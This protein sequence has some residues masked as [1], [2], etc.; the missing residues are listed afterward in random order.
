MM[1][2][3]KLHE[4]NIEKLM[5]KRISTRAFL[6]QDV[7]DEQLNQL[8]TLA[9]RAPSWK[10][11]QSY[12][13]AF[14]K[15]QKKD[16]LMKEFHQAITER[17][18]LAP[19]YDHEKNHPSIIKK[20]MFNLGMKLY[21]HMRIERK[22]K[23]AR[24]AHFMKNY[25]AFGAPVVAFYYIPKSLAEWTILDLGILM[26]HVCLVAEGM[27]LATCFQGS[28]SVYPDIVDKYTGLGD[29]MKMIVGMSL[30]YPDT[31]DRNNSFYSDRV[32]LE[33]IMQIIE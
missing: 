33:E 6:Q 22:D 21:S 23:E 31:E 24:E 19:H 1:P 11:A 9:S 16:S 29:E 5:K 10:N 18:D 13:I 14:V 32:P 25:E 20:R 28:L 8:T 26:G 30:G 17:R 15:G 12:K 7:S 4:N 2:E 3:I 27:G